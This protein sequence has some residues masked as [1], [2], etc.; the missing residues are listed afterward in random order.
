MFCQLNHPCHLLIK[1]AYILICH[2]FSALLEHGPIWLQPSTLPC[3]V[4]F[5]EVISSYMHS[6]SFTSGF[7]TCIHVL[8][9]QLL[10]L[11]CNYK[12]WHCDVS[13]FV[14]CICSYALFMQMCLRTL[15]SVTFLDNFHL[16]SPPSISKTLVSKWYMCMFTSIVSA[17]FMCVFYKL[18]IALLHEVHDYMYSLNVSI[19]LYISSF[20][21]AWR[22]L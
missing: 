2:L 14:Q 1:G 5:S 11:L 8:C 4:Q 22:K 3:C 13:W 18:A 12:T 7:F 10:F 16:L 15:F 20:I 21:I 9:D 6:G 19:T 17:F